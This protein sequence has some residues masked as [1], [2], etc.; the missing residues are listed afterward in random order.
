MN[1]RDICITGDYR[2]GT[3]VEVCVEGLHRELLLDRLA[4]VLGPRETGTLGE[5]RFRLGAEYAEQSR[6]LGLVRRLDP[7]EIAVA[8]WAE[9]IRRRVGSRD[10]ADIAEYLALADRRLANEIKAD[11]LRRIRGTT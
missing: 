3:F 7:R 8:P 10:I 1:L 11:I 5:P 9:P 4:A 6:L 2:G